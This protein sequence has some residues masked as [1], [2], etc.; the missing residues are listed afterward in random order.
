MS[1]SISYPEALTINLVIVHKQHTKK[2]YVHGISEVYTY[3]RMK[4]DT[5]I[6]NILKDKV[7]PILTKNDMQSNVDKFTIPST[8]DINNYLSIF[9]KEFNELNESWNN[10]DKKYLVIIPITKVFLDIK[11]INKTITNDYTNTI[12][13]YPKSWLYTL[14]SIFLSCLIYLL[15]RSLFV[16]SKKDKKQFASNMF[17]HDHPFLADIVT[18]TNRKRYDFLY[19]L[20]EYKLDV[21]HLKFITIF[22]PYQ[23]YL[24]D[25]I[26]EIIKTDV[27]PLSFFNVHL[28]SLIHANTLN[29]GRYEF[30]YFEQ[31][32]IDLK[33]RFS[34]YWF[35]LTKKFVKKNI[36][37]YV[38]NLHMKYYPFALINELVEHD[39]ITHDLDD[40][41]HLEHIDKSAF[42]FLIFS[43]KNEYIKWIS[44]LY[45]IF[46]QYLMNFSNLIDVFEQ[47]NK[48]NY[49]FSILTIDVDKFFDAQSKYLRSYIRLVKTKN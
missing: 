47:L 13:K 27:I 17:I 25:F 29:L 48:I 45:H 40:I 4:L 44:F 31:L 5:V 11:S 22:Y 24:E 36:D 43:F 49:N 23:S 46:Y 8:N 7:F 42:K 10:H 41:L 34:Y 12:F 21:T 19:Y 32:L 20:L 3:T 37:N 26:S 16:I 18:D 9:Q 35:R 33:I 14:W 38:F 39:Y 28:N 6:D 30:I 2:I 15:N 1:E